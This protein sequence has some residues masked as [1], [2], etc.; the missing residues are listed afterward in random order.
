MKKALLMSGMV[1]F[2]SQTA[3]ASIG[4]GSCPTFEPMKNVDYDRYYGYWYEYLKDITFTTGLVASCV[5]AQYRA[6]D[7][8]KIFVENE[9]SIWPLTNVQGLGIDGWAQCASDDGSCE[10]R[11][12]YGAFT[13]DTNYHIIDTDYESYA[14]LYDCER[15]LDTDWMYKDLVWIL[16]REPTISWDLHWKTA[17][18]LSEKLPFYWTWPWTSYT[19]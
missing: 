13:G 3:N 16:T 2:M 15:F 11:L 7:D 17:A 8:G 18:I 1:A 9:A 5:R 12:R 10:V 19:W 6:R 4:F 14:I